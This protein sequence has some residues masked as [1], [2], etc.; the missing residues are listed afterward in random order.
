M[1][2]VFALPVLGLALSGLLSWGPAV[3]M[4][5]GLIFIHELGHFLMARRMGMPVE[6]FSLG[7]GP[8]LVGFKWRETDV[9]LAA[10]PLGG[11]VKLVGFN[12]EE[13]DAEDPHGFLQQPAWKRQL[14]YAG[15]ILFNVLAAF[16]LMWILGT[17]QARVT[18]VK[19]APS[20]LSVMDVVAGS[21]AEQGGV[22][23][24]DQILSFGELAFPGS[25]SDAAIAYIQAHAGQAIPVTLSR[26]GQVRT[27]RLVPQNQGGKGRLGIQFT[28]SQ[29]IYERRPLRWADPGTGFVNATRACVGMAGQITSGYARFFTFRGNMKEMGG[30]LTIARMGHEAAKAGWITYLMM[31]AMISMNLAILNALPIPFLDGGHMVVLAFEKLRGRDLS[32]AVKERIL[33]AGFLMLGSLMALVIAMDVWRLRH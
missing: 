8:R 10:L 18:G 12:P 6:V 17:D 31:T 4:I 27:L 26:L 20:P 11:Y 28:P 33:T 29:S 23:R 24:G 32:L 9:R 2:L 15:G 30:P 1:S 21:A 19:S 7:F 3:L 14:F 5:G 22:Q 13:P 25:T 16:V